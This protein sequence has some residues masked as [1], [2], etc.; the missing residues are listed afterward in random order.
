MSAYSASAPVTDSTTAANAKKAVLAYEASLNTDYTKWT[1]AERAKWEQ[2]DKHATETQQEVSQ[3]HHDEIDLDEYI[4][5]GGKVAQETP[6]LNDIAPAK[7]RLEQKLTTDAL[8]AT[9]TADL[10]KARIDNAQLLADLANGDVSIGKGG[11]SVKLMGELSA[12]TGK[13][14]A[15][16][17]LIDGTLVWRLGDAASVPLDKVATVIAHVHPSGVL[18]FSPADQKAIGG[19]GYKSSVLVDPEGNARRPVV[20]DGQQI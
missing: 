18:E 17:R 20:G 8:P 13:E 16:L 15:L 14:V 7:P 3:Y 2:L 12:I 5:L 1:P 19:L 9:T 10:A 4:R 11:K 6:S